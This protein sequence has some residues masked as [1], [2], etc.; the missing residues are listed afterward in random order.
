MNVK[1]EMLSKELTKSLE[2]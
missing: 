1:H 2:I